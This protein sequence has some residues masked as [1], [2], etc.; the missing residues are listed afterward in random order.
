MNKYLLVGF[1]LLLLSTIAEG[2][3]C[4][5]CRY[6]LGTVCFRSDEPCQ[7]SEGQYCETTEVYMGQMMLYKK[8][9][10]GKLAELCDRTEKRDSVFGINFKRSCCNT[11]LCNI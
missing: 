1:S 11:S 9:G 2:L 8:N 3:V 10:C 7:A 4:N 6:K 5:V